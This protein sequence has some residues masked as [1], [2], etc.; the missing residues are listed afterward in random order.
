MSTNAPKARLEQALASLPAEL[1]TRIIKAYTELKTRVLEGQFDAVGVRAGRFAETMLRVLQHLLTG[2]Y[3]P[4]TASLTNFKGECERLEKTPT[5]AGAEGLRILMPRALAF[6]Y[7][8]RNKRDF[9]HAGG[10]VDANEID[11][12]T[13]TR[14]ADWSLSELVR[15]CHKI[16]IEDA[17]LLCDA[18]AERS[19]PTIWNVLGRKRI[20]DTSLSYPEQVLFLLYSE[21]DK[22]VATEDLFQWTEHPHSSNFRRDVLAKLHASRHIEWDR[23]TEMAVISPLG[24]SLV[25]KTILPKLRGPHK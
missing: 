10:E 17:Q 19:L 16:P 5:S 9:G 22:G 8:L 20:L 2:T 3:T 6:L 4:F 12:E 1:R 18:I 15:V 13:A 11:S 24:V 21:L 25:E 14:L 23:E 7:T